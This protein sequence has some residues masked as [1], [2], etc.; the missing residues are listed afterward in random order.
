MHVA[1]IFCRS[2]VGSPR[3]RQCG[4][5][6]ARLSS[7]RT[8]LLILV[9]AAT[10]PAGAQ[11][12]RDKVAELFI[13]GSGTNPLHLGG[14]A[15]PNNPAGIQ[16][17]GDHFIP[18]SVAQNGSIINFLTVAAGQS[19]ANVPIGSSSSGETFRFEGGAPVRT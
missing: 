14:T 15:D 8:S 4:W 17:H 13:F 6:H 18:A 7:M 12:L 10:S 5:L 16:S 2:A 11:T 3:A 9:L 19:V 1:K